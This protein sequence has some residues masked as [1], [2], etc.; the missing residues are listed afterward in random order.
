MF[1]SL[2]NTQLNLDTDIK[3][4]NK[5]AEKE[6]E[7]DN[8]TGSFKPSMFTPLQRVR[9]YIFDKQL[10]QDS[11]LPIITNEYLNWVNTPLY[12]VFQN[13]LIPS[14]YQLIKLAKRGNNVYAYRVKKKLEIATYALKDNQIKELLLRQDNRNWTTNII[15][16]TLTQDIKLDKGNRHWHWKNTQNFYNKFITNLRHIFGKCWVIGSTESTATAHPHKHLLIL[17]E[18]NLKCFQDKN[19]KWRIKEKRELE[20]YWHSFIDIEVPVNI[21]SIINY[22][23]K[24]VFKQF[25]RE[26]KVHKDVLSLTLNWLYRKKAFTISGKHIL[27]EIFDLIALSITQNINLEIIKEVEESGWVLVGF[28]NVVFQQTIKKPPNSFIIHFENEYDESLLKENMFKTPN[29]LE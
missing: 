8:D 26:V 21:Q 12:M 9:K 27:K 4:F 11:D 18:R 19:N 2:N 25:T 24:D 5:I 3:S 23:I 29:K 13:K 22:L 6:L 1:N 17:T 10:L 15:F 7:F 28:V 14:I 20:K 16:V